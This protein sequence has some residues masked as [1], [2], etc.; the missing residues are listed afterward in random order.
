[1]TATPFWTIAAGV[2]GLL[3]LL[4]LLALREVRRLNEIR[5]RRA[6]DRR[7]ASDICRRP[8]IGVDLASGPDSTAV[9]LVS[10]RSQLGMPPA[11]VIGLDSPSAQDFDVEKEIAE[12][13][14]EYN[15]T[16]PAEDR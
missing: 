13:H 15:A 16:H 8:F 9:V 7:L 1:M 11:K 4:F 10:G 14:K 5:T 2:I 3:I 12:F 6:G